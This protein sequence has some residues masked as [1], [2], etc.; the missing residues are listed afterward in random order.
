MNDHANQRVRR[1]LPTDPIEFDPAEVDAWEADVA[2]RAADRLRSRRPPAYSHSGELDPR[3]VLWTVMV[4]RGDFVNLMLVGEVGRV[5]TWSCWEAAIRLVAAGFTGNV[6]FADAF[7]LRERINRDVDYVW[8]H[9]LATAGLLVIDDLGAFAQTEADGTRTLTQVQ[10]DH[11]GGVLHR[12]W[13][14]QRPTVITSN[15]NNL[16]ALLGERSASRIAQSVVPVT[17]TGPD[18]RRVKGGTR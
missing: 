12:R 9:K 13:E 15:E 18:R 6:E 1:V 5:K 11:V 2:R 14:Q 4:G 10:R 3:I 17:L 8:L 16:A 7:G